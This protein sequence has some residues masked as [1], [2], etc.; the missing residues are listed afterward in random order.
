MNENGTSLRETAAFFNIPSCETLRKWKVAYETEGLDAL[1][2][3]KKGRLTMAKEK[4]KLQHL[5]QN[6]VSLEGSIEALQAENERLRMEN[7]YLK[8]LNA[9]V[10]KKKTSQTK[11]KRN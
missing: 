9:L 11:T 7:D 5:K 10:Q 3:K 4:A 2:S 6:E 8:K 1:K